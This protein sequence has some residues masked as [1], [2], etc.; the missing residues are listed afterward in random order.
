[1]KTTLLNTRRSVS[2][3]YPNIEKWVEKRRAAEFFI[4]QLRGVWIPDETHFR[5]FDITSQ[6][7]H[8]MRRKQRNKIENDF[9]RVLVINNL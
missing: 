1:M 2:S 3:A 7:D 5:V 8:L 9:L 4:N 6:T